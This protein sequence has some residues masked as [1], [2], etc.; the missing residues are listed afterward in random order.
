MGGGGYA[1]GMRGIWILRDWQ[2]TRVLLSV[3]WRLKK[4]SCDGE[5]VTG[6]TGPGSKYDL[7][8]GQPDHR[9]LFVGLLQPCVQPK[10]QLSGNDNF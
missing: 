9:A 6:D 10:G 2:G 7:Q 5:E 1:E 4:V 8:S 3:V